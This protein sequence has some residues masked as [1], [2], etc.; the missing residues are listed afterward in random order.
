MILFW[1]PVSLA[2]QTEPTAVLEYFE[3]PYGDM[4]ITD[5][6]GTP[7]DYFDLG[8]ELPPGFSISTG[9]GF[10]EIRLHP[11][12]TILKLAEDTDFAITNLQGYRGS[13]SNEFSLLAGKMRTIAA[14]TSGI[15]YYNVRTPSAVMGV[16]GTDFINEVGAEAANLFVREGSVEVI[17]FSGSA[18]LATANQSVNTL[19]RTLQAVDLPLEQINSLFQ[20]MS[21][22][23]ISP[24]DVP[25][26]TP[27]PPGEE[28]TVAEV[29]EAPAEDSQVE[30]A[31]APTVSPEEMTAAQE[32][33]DQGDRE[34]SDSKLA[35]VLRDVFGMEIGT[36]TIDGNTYSKVILQPTI[37][38]GKLRLGLY[39]P[40]IYTDN[41]F[42]SSQWYKPEGNDEWSFGTDQDGNLQYVMLDVLKDTMLKI[43]FLE[44]GAQGWDPF[45]VKVGN[46]NNMSIGHGAIMNNYAND[47]DFPA[48]RK[49]G[50]NA[51][52]DFGLPGLELVGDNLA[53]PSIVGGRIYF[54]PLKSYDPF[55]IGF[56]GIA[57]L[58]PARDTLI[59]E[60]YGDPWL[61]AFGM[62]MELF[63]ISRDNFRL[64]LF[65][66]A[67]SMMPVFREPTGT[68]YYEDGS[69]FSITEAGAASDIWLNNGSL[70]NYG[71]VAGLRGNVLNFN[72]ALEYR[73]STGIYKPTLF[74]ALY[75]R[76]KIEYLTE[77]IYYLDQITNDSEAAT[78]VVMG[79]Y[80]EGG[81]TF[82]EKVALTMGYYWPWE[83]TD[84]SVS[85]AGDDK[86]TLKL[87]LLD[88]LI[89]RFPIK[90]SI[91]YERTKFVDTFRS[92]SDLK[93]FDA[94]TVVYGELVYPI[95]PTLDIVVGASTT[96]L[97]DVDGN[98]IYSD[99]G[100][101][102]EVA[103]V[104]NI[105]TR[106]HF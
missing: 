38:A 105:E 21:F 95:A 5:D 66:D 61:L 8:E 30:A 27:L 102:P 49:V 91:S 17:P 45:Y 28:E 56:T 54:N 60:H 33:E 86:F 78:D 98:T 74:N 87:A 79:I 92:G 6:T 23:G 41:M 50:L 85:F 44:Y 14:K 62:D 101:T 89:P 9:G 35:S 53:D 22:K 100:V 29:E 31:P 80:G 2:A 64:M 68:F 42:D 10:A 18:V 47:T 77:M 20:S 11:N 3:D 70:R 13:P 40:I 99:D 4:I 69:S 88:S 55:Q 81:V 103:P 57:D 16:R 72:W 25:G 19:A 24:A 84:G 71:I 65:A 34:P 97:T 32:G 93:L 46:L 59:P 58:F 96:I 94:N 26:H 76:N 48:I 106:I 37:D 90:G 63:K 12:G 73:F 51:G 36:T 39:L 43:K 67:S 82:M 15:N 83:I 75:D 1:L 52:F 104:I 7:L